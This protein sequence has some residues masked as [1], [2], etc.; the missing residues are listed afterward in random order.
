MGLG[1]GGL[2]VGGQ[3]ENVPDRVFKLRSVPFTK[4]VTPFSGMTVGSPSPK[5]MEVDFQ[6]W[7][8]DVFL[9]GSS[10]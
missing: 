3:R 4:E 1:E 5:V 8:A 9:D 6:L 10:S 2:T 7:L